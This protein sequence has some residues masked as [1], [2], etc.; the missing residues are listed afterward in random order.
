MKNILAVASGAAFTL[1]GIASAAQPYATWLTDG[2]IA[3][4]IVSKT[5][6]YTESTFYIGVEKLYNAT[7]NSTYK[8]YIQSQI[9]GV[10]DSSGAISGWDSSV[11]NLDDILIGKPLIF[12]YQQTKQE[13]YKTAI[14]FLRGRLNQHARTKSG[15]FWHKNPAYPNQMW[16]DGIFMAD[17][18]YA[19]YTALFDSNNQTAW[20]DILLQF[21]LIEAHT[22]DNSSGLLFHGY[23]ESFARSWAN[24]VTG[25]SPHVWDRAVGWYFVALLEVLDFFPKTHAGYSKIMG[26]YTSLA[27]A[28]KKAQDTSGGWWL[29]MD[30]PYPGQPGNYIES[31]AT[32]MFTYGWLKGIRLGYIKASDY[33][34]PANKAYTL[35]TERF[36][37][38]NGTGGTLNWEGTVVIGSLSGNASYEVSF[39]RDA[40]PI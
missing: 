18:F 32:A 10:V 13:K 6:Y 38:R 19:Q 36:V 26:Y 40:R 1:A 7:G 24:P 15:G 35:M 11:S 34:A 33:E 30:Q 29:V 21:D 8:S 16:L 4:S 25:A 31:S 12:L 17:T 22:R 2:F 23:D 5:R 39:F 3:R 27:A 9:D 14:N 20:D 37:A 28:L